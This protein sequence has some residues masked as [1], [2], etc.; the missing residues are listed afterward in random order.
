[1]PNTKHEMRLSEVLKAYMRAHGL[2]KHDEMARVLGVDRTLVSKYLNGSRVCRDVDQLRRFA[3]AMDLP[4]E[5]FG[6]V[7]QSDG[8]QAERDEEGAAA[9]IGDIDL[10]CQQAGLEGCHRAQALPAGVP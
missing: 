8:I 5:T 9:R 1:M 2:S 3:D 6:L 10:A 4:P 7:S